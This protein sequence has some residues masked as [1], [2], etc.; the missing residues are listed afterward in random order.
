MARRSFEDLTAGTV[1]RNP[2][3][4]PA[5]TEALITPFMILY[6]IQDAV[7]KPMPAGPNTPSLAESWTMA[8]DGVGYDAT[9][10]INPRIIYISVSTFGQTGPYA[11]RG[12]D[13]L[14]Q[15]LTGFM[16]VTSLPETGPLKAGP[17]VADATCANLV[18]FAA[19][20]GSGRASGRGSGRPSRS[21]SSLANQGPRRKCRRRRDPRPRALTAAALTW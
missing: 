11:G 4:S 19:M 16:A 21:A 8:K 3:V 20:V 6:A 14:V 7:A 1:F 10:A 13:P 5:E 15:A 12:I 2:S 18:A 9:R 17:A